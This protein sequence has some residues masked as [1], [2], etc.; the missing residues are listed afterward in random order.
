[1]AFVGLVAVV[2]P[3]AGCSPSAPANPPTANDTVADDS[4]AD[5]GDNGAKKVFKQDQTEIRIG[6]GEKFA[7]RLPQNPSVGDSWRLV[8]EPDDSFV[9]YD[10]SSMKYDTPDPQPGA[11]GQIE[12]KFKA[13]KA[14][15]T[16]VTL[17]NCYRCGADSTSPAGQ[18]EPA[19]RLTFTIHVG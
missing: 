16:T 12:F 17:F 5:A 14:G 6:V 11:A 19:K 15:T 10:G 7:I 2:A 8:S 18:A 13:K 3:S 4:G 9:K 1:L